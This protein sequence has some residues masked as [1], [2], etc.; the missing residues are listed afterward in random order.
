MNLFWTDE[1]HTSMNYTL[2]FIDVSYNWNFWLVDVT[3]DWRHVMVKA[4]ER[5]NETRRLITFLRRLLCINLIKTSQILNK[6]DVKT[7]YKY[8]RISFFWESWKYERNGSHAKLTWR[9]SGV[10]YFARNPLRSY[11]HEPQ[12]IEIYF[13]NSHF[14]YPSV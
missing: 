4:I 6:N 14:I 2:R 5:N 8:K 9:P 11:F 3:F 12:K 13:L 7:K 10:T 1:I